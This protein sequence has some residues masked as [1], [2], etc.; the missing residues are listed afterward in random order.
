MSTDF[1]RAS[2]GSMKSQIRR[3]VMHGDLLRLC[4]ALEERLCRCARLLCLLLLLLFRPPLGG[5]VLG[6]GLR[7]PGPP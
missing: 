6:A 4:L 3:R 2:I 5:R 1:Q 7:V